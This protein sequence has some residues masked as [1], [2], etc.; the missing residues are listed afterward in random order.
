MI[1]S[2]LCLFIVYKCHKINFKR[3]ELCQDSPHLIKSKKETINSINKKDNKCFQYT[4]TVTLNHKQIKKDLQRI[5]KIKPFID[6]YNWEGINYSS[7]KDN[8]KTNW[9]NN[10]AITKKINISC[11]YFKT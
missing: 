7:E 8:W 5:T 4:V 9:K 3:G 11:L 2:W 10:L 6:K 1:L